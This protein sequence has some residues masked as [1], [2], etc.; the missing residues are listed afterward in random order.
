[1]E[2][3][4]ICKPRGGMIDT[5]SLI[6]MCLKHAVK[7]NRTLVIDTRKSLHF[8]DGFFK[9]FSSK[10]S[11][12][13]EGDT[14]EIYKH[15]NHL[16]FYPKELTL[17]FLEFDPYVNKQENIDLDKNYSEDVVIYGH[18]NSNLD[19]DIFYFFRN[20]DV[21]PIIL[22]LYKKRLS[23]LPEN[24]TAVHVRNSDY[25]SDVPLFIHEHKDIIKNDNIFLA[26]DDTQ[27]I[28]LFKEHFTNVFTFTK[29]NDS[30][31]MCHGKVEGIH[32]I[33]RSDKDHEQFNIDTV[34]DFLLLCSGKKYYYSLKN[35]GFSACA[36]M[37]FDEKNIINQYIWN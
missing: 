2:K 8:K 17:D 16:S 10:N 25:K 6:V 21:N 1:M 29:I 24:Y 30:K 36:K 33:I 26:T 31:K 27:S 7:F 4:I 34:S 5:F 32:H 37:L 35:S 18:V 11:K 3:W 20:F 9:Y 13:F 19:R 22:D 14:D 12:I 23:L 28:Q 15:I